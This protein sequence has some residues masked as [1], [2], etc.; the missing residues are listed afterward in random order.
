MEKNLGTTTLSADFSG[1]FD[2]I[3]ELKCLLFDLNPYQRIQTQFEFLIYL[4]KS[5]LLSENDFLQIK[6]QMSTNLLIEPNPMKLP[7]DFCQMQKDESDDRFD[8][9]LL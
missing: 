7:N 8:I 3:Q 4:N 9:F 2:L 1:H 6:S 5:Q